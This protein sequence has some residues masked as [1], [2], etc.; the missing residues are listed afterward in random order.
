[1]KLYRLTLIALLCALVQSC[2]SPIV[3]NTLSA[4]A[5]IIKTVTG[6][7]LGPLMGR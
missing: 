6:P 3:N 1:M 2:N 4:P 7:I 5:R